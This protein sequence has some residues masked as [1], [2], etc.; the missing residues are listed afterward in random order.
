MRAVRHVLILFAL[1]A[2]A[3]ARAQTPV[4][5]ERVV[6][7]DSEPAN[8]LTYGGNYYDQRFS[9]LKQLTP[10]NVGRVE[11]RVGVSAESPGGQRGDIA[12]RGRR[13]HVRD[14]AAKHG[15]GARRA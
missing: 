4:P 12:D 11:T 14:R 3:I 9:G 13:N 1:L 2:P 15:D 6:K 8:W 10:Q 7:S 5:Y